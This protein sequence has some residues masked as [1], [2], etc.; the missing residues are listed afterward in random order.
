MKTFC[1]LSVAALA[2]IAVPAIADTIEV[3]PIPVNGNAAV[4][5][6]NDH[7]INIDGVVCKL[8]N[9]AVA[10][11]PKGCNYKVTIQGI[12]AWGKAMDITVNNANSNPG[13]STVCEK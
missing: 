9:S 7:E 4:P 8:K 10:I 5:G 1:I 2:F 13:C 3:A 11:G 12:N 6:T